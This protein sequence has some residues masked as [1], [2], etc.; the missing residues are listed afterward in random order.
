[1]ARLEKI[2]DDLLD[3]SH[4][5]QAPARIELVPIRIDQILSY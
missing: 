1:V 3:F 2:I 4:L 5:D